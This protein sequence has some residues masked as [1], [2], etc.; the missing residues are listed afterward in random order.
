LLQAASLEPQTARKL[1][2]AA[3]PY[4]FNT[5]TRAGLTFLVRAGLLLRD[6]Y[7]L[8]RLPAAGGDPCGKS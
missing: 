6:E 3:K 1:I 5:R 4:K 7:F 2:N 8:Y